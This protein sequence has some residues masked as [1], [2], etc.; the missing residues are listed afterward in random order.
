MG[1]L[2]IDLAARTGLPMFLHMRA[3]G[4]DFLKIMQEQRQRITGGVVHSFTGTLEEM[5]QILAMDLYIGVNGCSLK[6]EDNLKVVQQIPLDRLLLETDCPWCEVRPTHA[7]YKYVRTKVALNHA[8]PSARC[9]FRLF[10]RLTLFPFVHLPF[11]PV[12]FALL[13]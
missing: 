6:T 7:G 5:Q 4:D 3:A 9:I 12:S 10:A 11:K 8:I 13:V 2:E 1:P